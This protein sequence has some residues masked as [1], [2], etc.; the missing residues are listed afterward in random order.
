MNEIAEK[1]E[2]SIKIMP[3]LKELGLYKTAIFPLYRLNVVNSTIQKLKMTTDMVFSYRTHRNAGIIEV[4]R[5][6]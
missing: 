3:T 5:I 4:T 6:K 1:Q 2:V